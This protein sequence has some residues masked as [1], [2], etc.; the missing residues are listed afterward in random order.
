MSYW[1]DRPVLVTG[2]ASFIGSHLVDELCKLG[3]NVT[4]VDDLSS[5]TMENLSQSI[6][7]IK[8]MNLNLE[9]DSYDSMKKVFKG[10]NVVFH[11]AA[12]HG[13]RGF[14]DSHPADCSS[15]FAIDHR[16]FDVSSREDVERVIMAS[17]ACAYP[18]EL[19]SNVSSTY[20]LKESDSDISDLKK[21]LSADVEYGWAKLMGEVQLNAFVKQYGMKGGSLRF[22]TAYGPRENETHAIIALIHKAYEHMDPYVIWGNGKQ[23]RDFTYVSDIVSGS[24]LAGEKLS[25]G[26]SINLGTGVRYPL[27]DV[28]EMI[29]DIIGFKPKKFSFD[30]SKP[31]G[32]VNRGLD[33]SM[34]KKVLGWTPKTDLREGLKKTIEWYAKTHKKVGKVNERILMERS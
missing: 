31:T 33:N 23:L 2:G 6:K 17:S 12:I 25:D 4:V 10:Q 9:T 14:I 21:P 11:L 1:E 8:F 3:A 29:C 27:K 28:A 22:V 7:K 24:I 32:V 19:Q 20:L 15:N 30:T 13:G 5:G 26:S 16:V 34:A 18:P